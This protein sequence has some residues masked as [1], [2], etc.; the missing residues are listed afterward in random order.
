MA[1]SSQQLLYKDL[2]YESLL[3]LYKQ[4][5]A[6]E[7]IMHKKHAK[8]CKSLI[9]HAEYIRYLGVKYFDSKP[10]RI[11]KILKALSLNFYALLFHSRL[12]HIGPFYTLAE[13]RSCTIKS[14]SNNHVV[15]RCE[16]WKWNLTSGCN[17]HL[18]R[19]LPL[20]P[21]VQLNRGVMLRVNIDAA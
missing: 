4:D 19:S 20:T 21:K 7:V 1:D 11:L 14:S 3:R 13:P 2:E 10:K 18:F 9:S 6:V 5:G 12:V 17:W 16:S 15:L 8:V